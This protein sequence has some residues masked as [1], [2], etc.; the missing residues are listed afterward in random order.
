[1]VVATVAAFLVGMDRYPIVLSVGITACALGCLG[2]T[3]AS[4]IEA[5][6]SAAPFLTYK[7]MTGLGYFLS[8]TLLLILRLRLDRTILS[9]I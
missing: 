7:L 2:I 3:M 8:V 1:M 9:K 6:S 5:A 4:A